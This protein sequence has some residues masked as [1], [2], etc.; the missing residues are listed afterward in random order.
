MGLCDGV[1]LGVSE[2]L[3]V[4]L[5]VPVNDGVMLPLRVMEG[6]PGGDD[7]TE[8][9]TLPVTVDDTVGF[10][11]L[12]EVPVEE[13]DRTTGVAV[14][15]PVA[16]LDPDDVISAVTVSVL[17]PVATDVGEAVPVE[18]PVDELLAVPVCDGDDV[19]VGLM[20]MLPVIDRMSTTGSLTDSPACKS[21]GLTPV[22]F[23]YWFKKPDW[24]RE[25][26]SGDDDSR[27]SDDCALLRLVTM[28]DAASCCW[29]VASLMELVVGSDGMRMAM[30][31]EGVP[32]LSASLR[33][34]PLPVPMT[35]W[36]H[37]ARPGPN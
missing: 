28:L 30:D 19:S 3:R 22:L 16:V 5:A 35:S 1:W 13:A 18:V 8:A 15:L 32:P 34:L 17:L 4:P 7:V 10:A 37:T 11:L 21:T 27:L 23:V 33:L 29:P 9:V 25:S 14:A 31:T 20:V 26:I 24:D 36:Y 12:V 2:E 6:V